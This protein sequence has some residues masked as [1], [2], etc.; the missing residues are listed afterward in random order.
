MQITKTKYVL[1]YTDG[2]FVRIHGEFPYP[3]KTIDLAYLWN[4]ES[5][6]NAWLQIFL[7]Q[8][9][10]SILENK[11]VKVNLTYEVT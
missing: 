4:D 11:I 7:E 8:G 10:E 1:R 2:N 5:L 6:A 3:C 9:Y